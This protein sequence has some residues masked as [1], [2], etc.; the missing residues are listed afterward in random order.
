MAARG[1]K[2]KHGGNF[3]IVNAERLFSETNDFRY[4]ALAIGAHP[5]RP[6]QWAI[7]ACI[8]ERLVT[9]RSTLMA[10]QLKNA[11][12][13]LDLA[14]ALMAKHEDEY[15][16]PGTYFEDE[17]SRVEWYRF[18]EH[19]YKAKPLVTS[20]REA[21]LSI[22]PHE[23]NIDAAIRNL[24][25]AWEREQREEKLDEALPSVLRLRKIPTTSRINRV[26]MT[27][28]GWNSAPDSPFSTD[29]EL[30]VWDALRKGLLST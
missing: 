17:Q 19:R 3:Y 6:P 27:M 29:P 14:V 18:N 30:L 8:A 25:N 28:E 2:P 20:F 5:V 1:P 10:S 7:E 9:E 16:L 11:S 13:I 15:F 22:E 26:L 24:R 12:R 23:R 4:V 21:L